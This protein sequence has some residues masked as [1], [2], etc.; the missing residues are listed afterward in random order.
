M[1]SGRTHVPIAIFRVLDTTNSAWPECAK[2]LLLVCAIPNL[3][4][5]ENGAGME[6]PS[7]ENR[8]WKRGQIDWTEQIVLVTGGSDGLGRVL[9]ET[10]AQTHHCRCLDI[11]TYSDREEEEEGDLKFYRCDVSDPKAIEAVAER[12]KEEVGSPTIIVNNAGIVHGKPILELD[13]AE[14]KSATFGVNVFAHFYIYKAF[15]PDMIKRNSGHIVTMASILGHVGVSRVA[16]YC[17]S[18]SAAIL[19]HQS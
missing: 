6:F 3:R 16:D 11:K 18:K 7:L 2:I 4:S 10:F 19:L 14:L 8:S 13:S 15:L 1:D 17:A 5:T 9:V 12:I